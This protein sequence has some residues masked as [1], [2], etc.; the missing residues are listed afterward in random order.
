M[1][2]WRVVQTGSSS[3]TKPPKPTFGLTPVAL[4]VQQRGH[5]EQ[6]LRRGLYTLPG[7]R[8]RGL[9]NEGMQ[10]PSKQLF[11]S[12]YAADRGW[13]FSTM[14]VLI[15]TKPS[16]LTRPLRILLQ[17]RVACALTVLAPHAFTK[18]S[19]C[20]LLIALDPCWQYVFAAVYYGNE[21]LPWGTCSVITIP[22]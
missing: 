10:P 20:S 12:Q 11:G 7:G 4:T 15:S 19:S 8:L 22:R 3:P 17:F 1:L 5:C 18:R 16:S 21:S 14:A 2:S 13:K 6:P 9:R